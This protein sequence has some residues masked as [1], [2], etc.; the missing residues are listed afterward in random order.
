LDGGALL[1]SL[2]R[3]GLEHGPP[4]DEGVQVQLGTDEEAAALL[5]ALVQDGVPV[6][7]FSPSTGVLEQAYLA[8]TEDRR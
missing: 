1:Q 6:V 3:R 8:L 4:D 2:D 7:S 5:T